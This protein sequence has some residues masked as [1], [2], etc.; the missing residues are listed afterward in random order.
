[1]SKLAQSFAKYVIH[2]KLETSGIVEKP[3]VIGAIF[4]QTEGLLGN[5]LDLRELQKTGRIGRIEV[6]IKSKE[7]KAEGD[8]TIPSS[9]DMSETALIAS[10]LETIE[11]IGP[12]DAKII[13]QQVEDVRTLKRKYMVDRAKE[14]LKNLMD[15]TGEDSQDI[16]ENIKQSVMT[17]E[18]SEYNGLSCGPNI[19]SFEEIIVVEGRADV[20][21]LLKNGIK[22]AIAMEGSS[23]PKIITDL[24]REKVLTAFLDGDR[25]GD[26]DLRKLFELAEIDYVA[27]APEGKEVEDLTKKEIYKALRER[28]PANQVKKDINFPVQ[29]DSVSKFVE[30]KREMEDPRAAL[31]DLMAEATG[32]RAAF[33]V[34][35]DFKV[36]SKTPIIDLQTAVSNTPGVHAIIFDGLIN[37]AIVDLAIQKKIKYVVG[38]KYKERVKANGVRVFSLEQLK[39]R[40]E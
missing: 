8:I 30:Q 2:A 6:L 20:I 5:D 26:L 4:G 7:G 11:K 13:V 40:G 1:M 16:S 28:M 25:G 21:N 18:I 32:S 15:Y 10:S 9:L 35:K 24:S 14:I 29:Q 22:N 12:C 36:V 34:G 19:T 31:K 3:D 39:E 33:L 37:Q 38:A 23:V 17:W 27:R